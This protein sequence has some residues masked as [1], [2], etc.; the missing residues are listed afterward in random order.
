MASPWSN[1]SSGWSVTSLT[2]NAAIFVFSSPV[3]SILWDEQQKHRSR[4]ETLCVC[5]RLFN[6]SIQCTSELFCRSPRPLFDDFVSVCPMFPVT[7]L[8]RPR[9][10]L[11]TTR[12]KH[13]LCPIYL[14]NST[15]NDSSQWPLISS[16]LCLRL[17]PS[18]AG[19]RARI[20]TRPAIS[21]RDIQSNSLASYRLTSL[22]PAV[23]VLVE[24][25]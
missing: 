8:K 3:C 13:P 6:V 22:D 18:S 2:L 14:L 15:H 24:F 16:S 21:S 5:S 25:I 7:E 23:E 4:S 12:N 20:K 17:I 9:T 10:S 11:A 1:L 19:T